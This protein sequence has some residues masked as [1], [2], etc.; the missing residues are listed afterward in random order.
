[1]YKSTSHK[2][3][4]TA[5]II[6]AAAMLQGP[7]GSA[8]AADITLQPFTGFVFN[9]PIGI[10][11]HEPTGKLLLSVNYPTGSPNNL[12]LVAANG[13]PTP[14]SGLAGLTDE[15]KIATVRASACQGG[16]T[17][18]QAFTGNGQPGQLVRIS[19]NGAT[20]NNPWVTLP[21]EAATI[22]GS[23]IQ[24]RFCAAGGDLVVVTG[25]EQNTNPANDNVG[26]VWRVTAAGAATKIA[27]IGRHLEGVT[28][29]PNNPAVY[30]PLAGRILAGDED[31]LF[32]GNVQL[33]GPNGKIYAIN[34]NGVNDYFTIGNGSP[35]TCTVPTG[36]PSGCNYQTA[37]P[38][39]PEDLDNIRANSDFF[40]VAFSNGLV[41]TASSLDQSAT[42]FRD[43]CGQILISQEFP[44]PNTS[45]LSALR[46]TG[47][48]FA[49]DPLTSNRDG[50]ILQWEHVT[51]TSGQ[52]CFVPP[53]PPAGGPG[54]LQTVTQGGWG[55]PARGNNPGMVLQNNFS[56][57]GPVTIGSNGGLYALTFTSAAAI[58]G[59]LPQGGTPAALTGSAVN[60]ATKISVFAGQVLALKLNVSFSDV[61][62]LATNLRNFVLTGGPATGKTVAQVL[63]DAN[64][65]LGAG[66]LPSYVSSISQLNDVVTSI[67]EM[68]D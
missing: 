44:F 38:F 36:Q 35:T 68:F 34:P 51:F 56:K 15:L 3:A 57:I 5:G 17:V 45:G 41:Y 47:S 49:V 21:G 43:R 8:M 2:A 1:M 13:A 11:F 60:P 6:A 48:G 50:Q 10:D 30:G 40:G 67:N 28:T 7:V 46:W 53:V 25:N 39:N 22:R 61:G 64:K 19:A 4:L 20:V 9:A 33:N 26:N 32:N 29:V 52:D 65:A 14:F 62:V 55:A 23:L 18:G 58:R 12:D 59:F 54:V 31:R 27:T 16:F 24:D 63:A 42:N 66:G 37:T